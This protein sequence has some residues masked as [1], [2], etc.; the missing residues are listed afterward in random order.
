MRLEELGLVNKSELA[1]RLGCNRRTVAKYIEDKVQPDQEAKE[2]SNKKP[3]LIDPFKDIIIEK[4][5]NYSASAMAIYKFIKQKGYKGSYRPV[6]YFVNKHKN[7]ETKKATIRFETSPGHQ[8]QVDWKEEVT[9]ISRNGEV[10]KFNIFLMVLGFSRMKF[11]KITM[12]RSQNTLFMCLFEAISYFGGVPREMLFDNMKTVVD[13][14]KSSFKSI[15][16]NETFKH[17]AN[18]CGFTPITCRPYRAQTKGKVESLARFVERLRVYNGEFETYE[19]IEAL[20]ENFM[21]EVNHEEISQAT[22]E[23]PLKRYQIEKEYFNPLPAMDALLLYFSSHKEYK[24]SKESM[25]RYKG[26]KYSVPI[27]YI[28][29]LV[30]VIESET[31]IHVYYMEELIACHPKSD[32][33]FN[34][35]REHVNQILKSDALK[36]FTDHEIDNFVENNLKQMNRLLD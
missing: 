29:H 1:R 7:S 26:R 4:A 24:V 25:V 22:L 21:T 2:S 3:L 13:R 12:N 10:F 6:A 16:L 8:A 31:D 35:R 32:K 15:Q 30:H 20:A 27:G 19:D 23:I 5:D 18:D 33:M 17:F 9:M 14:A 11:I 28:G 36:H 34:Y